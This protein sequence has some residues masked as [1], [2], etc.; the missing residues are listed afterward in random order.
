M[1]AASDCVV[2]M[3]ETV[4][5]TVTVG[6]MSVGAV[7]VTEWV[8]E[9]EL[10]VEELDESGVYLAVSVFV[11]AASEPAGIVILAEPELRVVEEEA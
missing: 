2:V 1:M 5:V 6:V 9:A 10:Y 8:P 11:P 7:T 4:R 3:L